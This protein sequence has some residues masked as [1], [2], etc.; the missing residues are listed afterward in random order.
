M[1]LIVLAVFAFT[2]SAFAAIDGQALFEQHCALCHGIGGTGGRGPS[3]TRP[4]LLH[5]PDDAALKTVIGAGLEPEMPGAWFLSDEETAAVASY[6]RSLGKIAP[7]KL[8]G[9]PARGAK[10]YDAQGCAACHILGGKGVGYG[11]DLSE[12]GARRSATYLVESLV[13]PDAA[14]PE[15]FLL[16][17]LRTADGRTLEGI[18]LNETT[19]TIHIKAARGAPHSFRKSDLAAIE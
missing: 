19:F 4:K 7:Q 18:R 10:L 6:V 9:D 1:K 5:A 3:L 14:V 15:G 8:P 12:I 16:V 2:A 11:P 17:K 13:K